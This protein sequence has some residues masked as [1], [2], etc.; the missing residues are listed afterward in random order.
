MNILKGKVAIV[1][2]GSSGLGKA[3]ILKFAS[4]GAIV[5]NWDLNV[6]RGKAL[7]DELKKINAKVF[8]ISSLFYENQVQR[9]NFTVFTVPEFK[10]Q[11]PVKC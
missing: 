9:F 3:T 2:G 11:G 1:T 6:E 10:C 8:V 7:L 5:I 4:E